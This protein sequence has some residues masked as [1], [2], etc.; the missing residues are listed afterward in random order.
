MKYIVMLNIA[1]TLNL[2][3]INNSE[4]SLKNIILFNYKH[5]NRFTNNSKF[6]NIIIK[7]LY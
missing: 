6:F 7:Y 4:L 1:Y 3:L 5:T 2:L